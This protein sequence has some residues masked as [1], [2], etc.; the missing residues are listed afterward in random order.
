MSASLFSLS[1]KACFFDNYR[2]EIISLHLFPFFYF[3]I[4]WLFDTYLGF[5]LFFRDLIIVLVCGYR[6]LGATFI[7]VWT[8]KT[9]KVYQVR[10]NKSNQWSSICS[11]TGVM[12][13][14]V[15]IVISNV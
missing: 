12:D 2:P 1:N 6:R 14:I 9:S 11:K 15:T 7:Y 8:V 13:I 10:D 4:K 3:S 5:H